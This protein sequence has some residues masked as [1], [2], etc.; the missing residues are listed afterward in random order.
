M[1][2][3][4]TQLKQ[5]EV[6]AVEID[7]VK[8]RFE[9]GKHKMS[10]EKI[11]YCLDKY[12]KSELDYL[13]SGYRGLGRLTDNQPRLAAYYRSYF[14]KMDGN[15]I[16]EMGE[17]ITKIIMKA[18]MYP[19]TFMTGSIMNHSST[20]SGQQL[21]EKWVPQ[22]YTLDWNMLGDNTLRGLTNITN[23]DYQKMEVF[24]KKKNITPDLRGEDKLPSIFVG[25]L[26]AGMMLFA[27][28]HFQS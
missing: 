11:N 24:F 15:E 2:E 6:A 3:M 21:Y 10:L 27:S 16:S 13:T 8:K 4:L 22:I 25:Y 28:D 1:E 5:W 26:A 7:G 9:G 14:S 18:F 19:F 23:L 12:I 17:L 20:V